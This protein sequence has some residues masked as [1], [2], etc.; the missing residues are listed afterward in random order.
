[1]TITLFKSL[2]YLPVAAALSLPLSSYAGSYNDALLFVGEAE[3]NT[4]LA[5]TA[6]EQRKGLMFRQQ[7]ANNEAML[8]IYPQPRKVAFW[9][10]NTLIPLD[11]L[12]FNGDGELV[13]IKENIPPCKSKDCPTYPAKDPNIK[14][15]LE[16]NAGQSQLLDIQV[17]DRLYG[18]GI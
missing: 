18:C 12:F 16:I 6:N 15:V 4:E 8:F 11:M 13:E 14:Y 7:M 2:F 17:G 9:M 5:I 10:R 1:M 3:F